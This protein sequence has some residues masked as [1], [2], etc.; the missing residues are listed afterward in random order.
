MTLVGGGV[1]GL[2]EIN[3]VTEEEPDGI[4][5]L[6]FDRAMVNVSVFS[7]YESRLISTLNVL[8]LSP[9]AKRRV[10]SAVI[11]SQREDARLACEAHEAGAPVSEVA[12]STVDVAD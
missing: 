1:T 12:K 8:W 10:P 9:G 6:K 5:P 4:A 7:E 11:K 3:T 2:F